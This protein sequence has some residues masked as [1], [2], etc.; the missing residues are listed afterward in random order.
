MTLFSLP[1]F[2]LLSREAA[3]IAEWVETHFAPTTVD[4]A[5]VYDLTQ[6]PKNT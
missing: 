1:R 4:R 3:A 2:L 5:I 6:P